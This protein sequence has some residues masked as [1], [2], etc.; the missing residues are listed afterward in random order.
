MDIG[1]L[2]LIAETSQRTGH[3]GHDRAACGQ[4]GQHRRHHDG[5][6]CTVPV[7]RHAREGGTRRPAHECCTVEPTERLCRRVFF[8]LPRHHE[9]QRG[10]RRGETQSRHEQC[11]ELQGE[12]VDEAEYGGTDSHDSQRGHKAGEPESPVSERQA[13]DQDPTLATAIA[14]PAVTPV[15]P[16]AATM[17]TSSAMND[18]TSARLATIARM[19]ARLAITRPKADAALPVC[20]RRCLAPS[21]NHP[22]PTTVT[23]AETT[24]G[25]AV[26]SAEARKVVATGPTTQI[27]SCA[28][29]S[30]A[31]NA[32]T[33]SLGTNCGYSAR[34]T[35]ISGGTDAPMSTPSINSSGPEAPAKASASMATPLVRAATIRVITMA[36]PAM[37]AV[38]GIASASPMLTACHRGAG[39][40]VGTGLGLD[41]HEDRQVEHAQRQAGEQLGGSH[42][43]YAGSPE[44][45]AIHPHDQLLHVTRPT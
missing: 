40:C 42:V 24:S 44:H 19:T 31:N 6:G 32:R 10:H 25:I 43:Q 13:S 26:D 17:P 39:Q 8:D 4:G 23:P 33:P 1:G 12:I 41:V 14:R 22:V 34:T 27:S 28:V 36:R 5:T 37:R 29:V 21:R 3:P 45:V 7:G 18:A 2:R 16:R 15:R 9:I 11:A 35:G 20:G 30:N 38:T